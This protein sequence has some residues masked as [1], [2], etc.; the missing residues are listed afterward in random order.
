MIPNFLIPILQTVPWT[1][2]IANLLINIKVVL[3]K[4]IIFKGNISLSQ[5]QTLRFWSL[6]TVEVYLLFTQSSVGMGGARAGQLGLSVIHG[7]GPIET[8]SSLTAGFQDH[9]GLCV[10]LADGI[11]REAGGSH[12]FSWARSKSL[13][14]LPPIATGHIQVYGYI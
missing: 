14:Q 1:F 9:P 8:F 2:I 6:N 7:P 13:Y 10:Q 4:L 12:R 5:R 3:C 11:A